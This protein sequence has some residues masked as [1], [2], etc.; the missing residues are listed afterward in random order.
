MSDT[1]DRFTP[2]TPEDLADALAST[3]RF[4]GGVRKHDAAEIMAR[5]VAKRLVD[6]PEHAGFVVM[7]R[8]TIGGATALDRDVA[9]AAHNLLAD[10]VTLCSGLRP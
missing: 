9:F 4:D 10:L 8:P 2:A 7:K 5:I 3:L 1:P 6:H